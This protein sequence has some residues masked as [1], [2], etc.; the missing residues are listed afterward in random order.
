MAHRRGLLRS[1]VTL[2]ALAT[3]F[4]GLL[5]AG[6]VFVSNQTTGLRAGIADLESRRDV[7]EAVSGE[8]L[9]EWNAATS[10]KVI[11]ARARGIGLEVQANPDLVLVSHDEATSGHVPGGWRRYLSR[12][13]GGGS[14]QAAVD[15]M[16]L[17]AGAM[18]SLTPRAQS[19]T[20]A[21]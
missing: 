14:A 9:A 2:A 20:A 7:L 12:F 21:E 13:G 10:A 8:L 4:M 3:L 11:I 17:V 15:Q 16:G 5:L 1:K 18:I 6:S 19:R